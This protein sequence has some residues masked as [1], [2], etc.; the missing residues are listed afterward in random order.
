MTDN[1]AMIGE[2][3][4]APGSEASDLHFYN[5]K[6]GAWKTLADTTGQT[7]SF[8]DVSGIFLPSCDM[9]DRYVVIGLPYSPLLESGGGS[10]TDLFAEA[11]RVY[12]L[13]ADYILKTVITTADIAAGLAGGNMTIVADNSLSIHN[14]GLT[15]ANAASTLSL[16]SGGWIY[17]DGPTNFGGRE[18]TLLANAASSLLGDASARKS[19]AADLTVTP[20][21]T[22]TNT[23][24]LTR[25]MIASAAESERTGA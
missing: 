23:G 20:F 17:I 24:A 1:W 12:L 21:A 18:V 9:S 3:T 11:G 6:T 13:D 5:M 15:N 4:G 8:H 14:L 7:V 16:Y 25:L 22:I 10:M 19:G 2:I